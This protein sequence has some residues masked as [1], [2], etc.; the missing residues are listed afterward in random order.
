M[1]VRVNHI[2]DDEVGWI[3][4]GGETCRDIWTFI[5][6]HGG[7]TSNATKHLKAVH[8]IVSNKTQVDGERKRLR[9]DEIEQLKASPMYSRDPHR[10]RLLLKTCCIVF[11]NLRSE[12]ASMKTRGLSTI[13]S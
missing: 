8:L 7:K 9:E 11:N 6:L 5:P 12:A 1:G 3:C 13:P 10:L 4:F 2:E